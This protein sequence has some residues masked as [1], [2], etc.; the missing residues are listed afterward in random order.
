MQSSAK[1]RLRQ[2]QSNNLLRDA[3]D[4][5][6][7]LNSLHSK[8]GA[9]RIEEVVCAINEVDRLA[10]QSGYD[11][12]SVAGIYKGALGER[13]RILRDVITKFTSEFQIVASLG[14][15]RPQGWSQA[16]TLFRRD[17]TKAKMNAYFSGV[18]V[19]EAA[20][21]G[22]LRM[23]SQCPTCRTWFVIKRKDHKFCS[24]A[25]REKHFRGSKE[26]KAKRAEFMRKYRAGL[27]RMSEERIKAA[28][29]GK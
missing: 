14:S 13:A 6:K 15:P 26:G 25:C 8:E 2:K 17:Y 24:G 4:I 1:R 20:F 27:K 18:F 23:I 16:F 22:Y 10:A 5:A 11:R 21:G 3:I 19:L 7:Y 9:E 28:K 12:E 29:R